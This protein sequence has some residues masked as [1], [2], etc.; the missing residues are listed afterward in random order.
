MA[1]RKSLEK[2]VA[3]RT[4]KLKEALEKEKELVDI[5]NKFVSIVSHEFKLPLS[6]IG[7]SVEVLSKTTPGQQT[8]LDAI[9]QQVSNMRALLEDVLQIDK[10]ETVKLKP[11]M[12][13]LNFK[14]FLSGVGKEVRAGTGET[15]AVNISFPDHEIFI[16]SDE[17][18]LRNIFINLIGNAIKFSPGRNAVD[19]TVSINENVLVTSVKDSGLGIEKDDMDKLF[20]PFIRGS[21]TRNISGTGLGL[22]IVKR[23]IVALKG[24]IA[25]NSTPSVGTTFTV[26][27]PLTPPK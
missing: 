12:K 15:H 21:N 1:Y 4:F 8:H 19:V 11:K 27:I 7:N 6:A 25:V 9:K 5:K 3:D 2:Q 18:L 26:E 23:A 17:K 10:H 14:A 22:S 16:E 24:T 13:Q 20:Q